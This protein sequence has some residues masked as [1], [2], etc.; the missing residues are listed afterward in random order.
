M[1]WAGCMPELEAATVGGY[2]A[3]LQKVDGWWLGWA[4][5]VPGVN[6]QERTRAEL[7]E[8]LEVVLKEALEFNELDGKSKSFYSIVVR[9]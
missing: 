3:T 7:L 6:A 1:R 9:V 4:D 2:T 8:S 5:E